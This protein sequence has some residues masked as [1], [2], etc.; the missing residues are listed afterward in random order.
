MER[1]SY[2][3]FVRCIVTTEQERNRFMAGSDDQYIAVSTHASP[4]GKG[5][6]FVWDYTKGIYHVLPEPLFQVLRL[7]NRF[8]SLK[9]HRDELIEAG[10]QDDGSGHIEEMFNEL[11]RKGLLRT[12]GTFLKIL[13]EAST[14]IVDTVQIGSLGWVTRD[15][16]DVLIRSVESF[17]D[18]CLEHNRA[19][20]YR[21]F[22]DSP[23]A[24]KRHQIRLTLSD[25]AK[26]R[27]VEIYYAG[28]EEKREFADRIA[29]EAK[30]K[31]LPKQVLEFAFFDPFGI[32]YTKGANS[33]CFLLS[34]IDDVSLMI[35]DD[36]VSKYFLA[37]E[38]SGGL[39][40]TSAPD[41]TQFRF[42]TD[43]NSLLEAVDFQSISILES[44]ELLLGRSISD[45]ITNGGMI[46]NIDCTGLDSNSARILEEIPGKVVVTMTG[47]CGDSGMGS[48]RMLLGL[49]GESRKA[50]LSTPNHYKSSLVS[51]EVLRVVNRPTIGQRG[52]LMTM[53]CGFDNRILLPPF[54]PVLRGSDGL[55]SQTLYASQAESRIGYLPIACLH[56]PIEQRKYQNDEGSN[57]SIRMSDLLILLVR[58]FTNDAQSGERE[59]NLRDLGGYLLRLGEL[60]SSR[61]M[62]VIGS[63]WVAETS[64]YIEYLEYL[65]ALYEFQPAYWAEDITAQIESIKRRVCSGELMPEELVGHRA[66]DKVETLCQELVAAFGNLLYWW[67]TIW[68]TARSLRSDGK[69]MHRKL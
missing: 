61:F 46:D 40:L 44:H 53:I 6:V 36:V 65:L 4:A 43:R 21:I 62:G 26:S 41:P 58:S 51:R 59:K 28:E 66:E 19:T 63:V 42:F 35:D 27:S 68:E 54:F 7:S 31:G 52:L 39:A 5:E 45:C 30:V 11:V 15:R 2:V 48:P 34:S 37:S 16:P 23:D 64:R 69:M 12:K 17:I 13:A 32:G 29:N 47:V 1:H 60:D 3:V 8:R 24:K 50:M 67:P 10:W 56:D 33:N 49:T 38:P 20:E 14:R 22:D 57:S 55:F 25:L 18:N 9:A